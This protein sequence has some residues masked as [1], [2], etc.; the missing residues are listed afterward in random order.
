MFRHIVFCLGA[1]LIMLTA[2]AQAQ[3]PD[4][5]KTGT[6]RTTQPARATAAHESAPGASRV[7]ILENG[8][9]VLTLEDDR[10]PLVSTRLY[11]HAGSAYE[12]PE[13]AGISH[14]LEHMVFKGTA[15]RAPGQVARDVE[16]AGGSLNAATSFDY[17][18]YYVDVPAASWKLALD[19][20][21]D[22]IF[23]AS[24]DPK[25]LE[26]E[27]DVIVSELRRGLDDPGSRLF[28]TMQ[29]EVWPHFSYR[30]PIIGFEDTIRATTS[31][32]LRAY[33]R[34]M[35]QPQSM[36]LV[37]VGDIKTEDVVA[38]A[39]RLYGGLKNTRDLTPPAKIPLP[40]P[41]APV[42]HLESGKWNK[43]YMAV[44]LPLP[45]L[46]N[47][48]VPSMEVLAHIL[49]GD[50]SSRLPREFKYK[51]RLVDDIW[52]S[53]FTMERAGM[54]MFR[55]TLDP[56]NVA[57]FWAELMTFLSG[58]KDMEFTDEEIRRAKLN[59]EDSLYQSKE[60]LSG[61]ASKIGYF[62]FFEGGQDAEKS[63][64]YGL[65]NTGAEQLREIINTY[66]LP[67]R[68]RAAVLTPKGAGLRADVLETAVASYWAENQPGTAKGDTV[69]TG[70]IRVLDVPGGKIVLQP[71]TTLPYTALSIVWPGGDAL[72]APDQQGWPNKPPNSC[73]REPRTG[74]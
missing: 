54:F 34:R 62:Q 69:D 8:L 67:G 25:E 44:A 45:G 63:Y 19:V 53:A 9:T 12:S 65:R 47:A 35:Y 58:L 50:R 15:N 16:S 52:A 1:A 71:D 6:A 2:N 30:W 17:T 41:S 64:L 29:A 61:L 13:Q 21:H 40:E 14:I 59:L 32:D 10:F 27:L 26:S 55:A 57:E 3:T 56:E 66:F 48:G 42:V 23:N 68:L 37:A 51:K 18:V 20:T 39:R 33:I 38:E 11:V 36:L 5:Q 74:P 43:V 49:G 60:T 28:K 46:D 7:T 4:T 70:E 24:L 73:P 22:M 31:E 72:L